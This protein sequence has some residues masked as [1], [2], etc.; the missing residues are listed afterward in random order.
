MAPR[1]LAIATALALFAVMLVG[2]LSPAA[3]ET[4]R[5]N[6][7]VTKAG[8][9]VGIGGGSGTLSFKGRTYRLA[10]GG[11]SAGTIGVSG[12][13]LVGTAENLQSAADIAGTYTAASAGVAIAGG[14]RTAVLQNAKGVVLRL[15]GRQV[16]FD[17]SL[18]LS[19]LTIRL[20]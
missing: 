12:T 13:E 7:N 6:L 19:G 15:Q 5:V 1:T 11:I 16:G 3:A 8:F 20:Q 17:A 9:I 14:A 4:G 10:L 18:S 2:P